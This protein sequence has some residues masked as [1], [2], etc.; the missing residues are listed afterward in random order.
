ME[1]KTRARGAAVLFALGSLLAGLML[2]ASPASAEESGG[3]VADETSTASGGCVAVNGSVCSGSGFAANDSTSSGD[4]VAIDGSVASGC[5]GAFGGSTASGGACAPEARDDG[6]P[7]HRRPPH[8]PRPRH[9]G[10]RVSEGGGV[11]EAAPA[12]PTGAV[13]L[14]FTGSSTGPLAAAGAVA[15]ALGLVLM[16]LASE[17]RRPIHSS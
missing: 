2:F 4:A 3:A 1:R 14:A 13:E 12:T 7:D 15:L 8:Q 9:R 16:A 6:E 17:R 5:S 11:A 10:D